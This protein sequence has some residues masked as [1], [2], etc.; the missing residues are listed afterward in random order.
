MLD[1]IDN[2]TDEQ[3]TSFETGLLTGGLLSF[4]GFIAGYLCTIGVCSLKLWV[5]EN[6]LKKEV[7]KIMKE[8]Q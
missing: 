2:M 6:K 4:A 3:R 8:D 1:F 7:N 5:E